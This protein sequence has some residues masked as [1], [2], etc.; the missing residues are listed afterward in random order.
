[1]EEPKPP[2]KVLGSRSLRRIENKNSN[3]FVIKCG[4]N[5]CIK[6]QDPFIKRAFLDSINRRVEEISKMS[7][8]LGVLMNIFLREQIETCSDPRNINLPNFLSDSNTTFASQLATGVENSNVPLREVRDFLERNVSV[9]PGDTPKR[10][11]G[12]MNSIVRMTEGYLTNYKTYLSSTFK[13]KQIAY[14][15]HWLNR[16]GYG[17]KFTAFVRYKINNWDTKDIKEKFELTDEKDKQLINLI[18]FHRKILGIQDEV[19]ENKKIVQKKV[20]V[21]PIW[22]KKNY[23]RIIVYYSVLSKYFIRRGMKGILL[24]PLC[25]MKASFI[26]A[27]TNVFYGILK[28]LKLT[29]HNLK[30]FRE[31]LDD[32]S[33][34]YFEIERF[35][36]R[37]QKKL[38]FKF[39]GTFNTDGT[40]INFHFRRPKLEASDVEIDRKVDP[41]VRVIANDPGRTTLFCGIEQKEDGSWKTYNFTRR[42]FYAESGSKKATVNCNRWNTK[43]LKEELDLLSC[44]NSR[45]LKLEEF[46]KYVRIINAN[47]DKFWNEYLKKRYSRQRFRLY[48][49]KKSSYDN[50]F[51]SLDDGSGKK[52]V[53]AYGDA[54]FA[55]NSKNE[56]SAPTT[57]L[58]KECSKWYS[59]V[60]VDEFRT[61]KLHYETGK[62][63]GKVVETSIKNDKTIKRQVRGLLFL[64]E[65]NIRKLINRDINAAKNILKCFRA[66]SDRPPGFNR[67]DPKLKDVEAPFTIKSNKMP[68]E[69]IL[70]ESSWLELF[71]Y[72][73]NHKSNKWQKSS[74]MDNIFYPR[75]LELYLKNA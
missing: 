59:T 60:K 66:G 1:M 14:I 13:G 36:T 55:S 52:I 40:A 9:I 72:S 62:V 58:Q 47:Y 49:G 31:N 34:D 42:Q 24:A 48:S 74:L 7:H 56:L 23:E 16:M 69:E 3:E 67:S 41:N 73:I 28:S 5:E 6:I 18:G 51:K 39:T 75:Q 2:D 46:L 45:A 26:H 57:T 21:S 71:N 70:S 65:N 15:S 11:Q 63:L 8:R 20:F 10:F 44:S 22:V 30:D 35:S 38:G 19:K 50:F 33:D 64:E 32:Y 54:G 12:D 68:V 37:E 53:I 29:K 43:N 4:L 25:R 27:D 61:T 17:T